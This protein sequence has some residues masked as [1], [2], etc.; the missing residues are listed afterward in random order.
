MLKLNR[1]TARKVTTMT[2]PGRHADG[3]NLYL[4]IGNGGKIW[5][6]FYRVPGT[7]K[8]RE[9]GLGS[10]ATVS[11]QIA[12]E[13]AEAARM[14][15]ARGVDPLADRQAKRAILTSARTFG[16]FTEEFLKTALNT[17]QNENHRD[18]WRS[19]LKTYAKP[20]WTKALRDIN[21]EDVR[22]CLEPIWNDRHETARRVRGR[23]ER[24]LSAAKAAGHR[25]GENPARWKD[26]LQ[27]IFGTQRKAKKHHAALPYK[28]MPAFMGELR[29]R[30]SVSAKAVELAILT[31]AR[32]GEVRLMRWGE[33]DFAEQVWTVPASR[34]KMRKEHRV[35]LTGRAIALLKSMKQ[36]APDALVFPGVKRGAPL[37]DMAMLEVVRQLRDGIT[38]H[39]FRSSFRDWA[40][41]ETTFP[42][43][44]AE[45]ALAH[46]IKDATE[47]AY[48]R[49]DALSRRR[50]LMQE[51]ERFLAGSTKVTQVAS[52]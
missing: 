15:L 34:M 29:G 14:M 13:K 24:V 46:K 43:D 42:R 40:G 22:A 28:E 30:D 5:T 39:G 17:F 1:L 33:I 31:A 47:A 38:T 48:R 50:K 32:T 26:N 35:P 52:N 12:R 27:P 2:E 41:D 8:L 36:G 44:V 7:G 51:W 11:L 19:T 37:S 10:A 18:Q 16:D 23:I 9:M 20:I 21:T 45:A 3:G 49:S 25:D 4:H 6:F